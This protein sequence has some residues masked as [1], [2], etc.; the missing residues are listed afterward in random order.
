MKPVPEN[1]RIPSSECVPRQ[2]HRLS[3]F[4][5]R[6]K[7]NQETVNPLRFRGLWS[8][9]SCLGGEFGEGRVE[10]GVELRGAGGVVRT[11]DRDL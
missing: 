3:D 4:H 2:K 6:E 8:A 9:G 1:K 11:R 5:L 7:N 10:K